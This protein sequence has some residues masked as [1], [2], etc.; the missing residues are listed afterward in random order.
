MLESKPDQEV[1]VL[2][3][4]KKLSYIDTLIFSV[5]WNNLNSVSAKYKFVFDCDTNF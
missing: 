1:E 5:Y 3:S 4:T 2:G